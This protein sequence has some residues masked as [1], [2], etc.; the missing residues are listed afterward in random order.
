MHSS[1]IILMVDPCYLWS[2][3]VKGRQYTHHVMFPSPPM[4][5]ESLRESSV[6]LVCK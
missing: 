3:I 5:L 2:F 4:V 6:F 1:L